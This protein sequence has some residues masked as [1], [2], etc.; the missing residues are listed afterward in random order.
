M[1]CF[2]GIS[3][4]LSHKSLPATQITHHFPCPF[5]IDHLLAPHI[6]LSIAW[7]NRASF[8]SNSER[9]KC[10]KPL[11]SSSSN[12]SRKLQRGNRE[13]CPTA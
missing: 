8:T 11:R 1:P 2:A 3:S 13:T 12:R 9:Q 6:P 4:S 10:P 7:M 5:S